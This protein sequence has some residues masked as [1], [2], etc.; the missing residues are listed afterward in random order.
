MEINAGVIQYCYGI[1]TKE[2]DGNVYEYETR[3]FRVFQKWE[4]EDK[5]YLIEKY[6]RLFV[7]NDDFKEETIKRITIWKKKS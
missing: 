4:Q 2:K 6:I 7:I 1:V 3:H 5:K